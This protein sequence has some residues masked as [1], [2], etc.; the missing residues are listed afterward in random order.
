[1]IKWNVGMKIGTGFAL[2]LATL[3]AIGT[4]SYRNT[5]HLSETATWVEHTHQVLETLASVLTSMKD[6]ETGQRGF[7]LTGEEPYLAPYLTARETIAREVVKLRSLTADN[8]DQQRRLDELAPLLDTKFSELEATI[9]LRK[10]PA[11]GFDAALRVV[12]TGKGKQVMDDIRKVVNEMTAAEQGLLQTRSDEAQARMRGTR[13]TII[14]GT[15]AAFVIMALVGFGIARNIGRPLQK[16]SVFAERIGAG[17]LTA[18]VT[19]SSRT[20]EIGVL[21]NAFALMV[22]NLQSQTTDL[23][24][25]ANVLGAAATQISASTSQFAASAEESAAAVIETTTTVEEVRQ[26]AQAASQKARVV[27]DS[28]QKAA[29]ISETSRKATKDS[30]EGVNRI[31]QQME[32]IAGS[33][34]RLSEQSQAIERIVSTVE[35]LAAQSNLLAVN[36]AIEAAKAGEQGKGFAVVAQEV[37]SLA[38]QSKQATSQV[39]TVL[40]DIQQATSAAVMASEQGSKAVEEGVQRSAEADQ[41]IETLS[42]T[43]QD[44]ARVATQIEASNRQQLVGVDQVASAMEDI[45]RTSALNVNSARELDTAANNL[46]DLG[47]KLKKL[48]AAYRL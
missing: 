11:Q 48:T 36:A 12:R 38:E 19:A 1:M 7:L 13:L 46:K 27:S 28:A 43:V 41:S 9:S 42:R 39:R 33:M 32:L 31:R 6:A 15:L 17:D 3:V 25:G 8:R 16:I 18:N 24:Q 29:Q 40:T 23:K 10:N 47:Q 22:G 35:D 5:N 21:T 34:V 44:A 2:A 37:K 45:K 30:I 14:F 4:V 26:T 20:D